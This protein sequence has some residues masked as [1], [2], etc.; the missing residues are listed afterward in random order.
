MLHSDAWRQTLLWLV[1]FTF[2]AIAAYALTAPEHMARGLGYTLQAPNGYNEFYAVYVGVWL[3]TAALAVHA[4]RHI[5]QPAFGDTVALLILAQPLGRCIAILGHGL[6]TGPL[7]YIF[8]LE[9]L[10]G[11]ALFIVRPSI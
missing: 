3:A 5:R 11:L 1:A 6:P 8:I 10:G 9:L 4:T 7:L 2:A